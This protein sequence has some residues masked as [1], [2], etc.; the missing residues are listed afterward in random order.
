MSAKLFA[1]DVT[2]TLGRL[3]TKHNISKEQFV[4]TVAA[5]YHAVVDEQEEPASTLSYINS[6]VTEL[7]EGMLNEKNTP[8]A[9]KETIN[10]LLV[11]A[12]EEEGEETTASLVLMM[13]KV[14]LSYQR[15][16]NTSS[17]NKEIN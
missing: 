16:F 10:S 3:V 5:L 8:Y 4:A 15:E 12:K 13:M 14:I 1:E 2:H 7:L 9:V 6:V 17:T 11:A